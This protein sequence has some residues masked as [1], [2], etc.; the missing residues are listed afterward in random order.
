MGFLDKFKKKETSPKIEDMPPEKL[1]KLRKKTTKNL[2]ENTKDFIGSKTLEDIEKDGRV[3]PTHFIYKDVKS[4]EEYQLREKALQ[5][6]M[7]EEY[8]KCVD[9]CNQGL[10]INPN[11][12]YLLYMRGRTYSDMKELEKAMD[13]LGIAVKLRDDFADAWYEI[14]RIHHMTNNMDLG[15]LA[16]CNAQEREPNEY[17]IYEKGVNGQEDP[18]GSFP[19]YTQTISEKG[20]KIVLDH[21]KNAPE[22][23]NLVLD[24]FFA[25]CA[26][27]KIF[28][29][30][31]DPPPY[32]IQLLTNPEYAS[33]QYWCTNLVQ[34]LN[35]KKIKVQE[36]ENSDS[37]EIQ[38]FDDNLEQWVSAVVIRPHQND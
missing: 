38:T 13:D 4:T 18:K 5:H 21:I 32:N 16:Y 14:G 34:A 20:V 11:S 8:Q 35:E 15:I 22:E 33:G 28:S 30:Y 29:E 7:I 2:F 1:K 3:W 25:I 26:Q 17:K 24:G 31:L 12:A 19:K 23:L 6:S 36:K 10:E 27:K 9:Y 37:I